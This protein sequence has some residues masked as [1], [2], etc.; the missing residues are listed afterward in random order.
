MREITNEVLQK[1]IKD[2]VRKTITEEMVQYLGLTNETELCYF[3]NN[4]TDILEEVFEV[5]LENL[6]AS[7]K[8][9]IN[10]GPGGIIL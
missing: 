2:A 5:L 3:Q 4:L 1:A 9:D 10:G 7:T 6:D 8:K